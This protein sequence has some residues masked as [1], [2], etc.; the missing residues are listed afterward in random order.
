MNEQKRRMIH[1]E[2]YR[3]DDPELT[4]DRLRCQV[5]VEQFNATSAGEAGLRHKL[6][7]DLFGHIGASSVVMPPLACDYGYQVRIGDRTFINYGAVILDAAAVT[8][9]DDVQIGPNVQ[10]LTST[11]RSTPPLAGP[12]RSRPR[13]SGSASPRGSAAGSSCALASP[14]ATRPWSVRVR[15]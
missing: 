7:H 3:P 15:W 11:P 14:W 9:G 5:L 4:N 1:G 2:R 8:I 13:R 12:A 6:L 10:L